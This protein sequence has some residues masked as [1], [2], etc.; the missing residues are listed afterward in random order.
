MLFF[1]RWS[2]RIQDTPQKVEQRELRRNRKHQRKNLE[3]AGRAV[4]C[5]KLFWNLESRNLWQN[6]MEK[7]E[8]SSAEKKIRTRRN[9]PQKSV[10][11]NFSTS[12]LKF[13]STEGLFRLTSTST[14]EVVS[15]FLFLLNEKIYF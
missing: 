4:C 3:H 12:S 15:R 6:R 11:M 8:K 10:D 7:I 1:V 5:W 14:S 13:N 9:A 2:T